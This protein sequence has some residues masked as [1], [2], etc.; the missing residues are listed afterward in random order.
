M[1]KVGKKWISG[2]WRRI[3]ALFIDGLIL[4]AVGFVLGFLLESTFVEIG[5]WGRLIGFSISLVY[6]GVM[7]SVVSNGQTLGKRALNIKVVNS[8]NDTISISKSFARYTVLAI[9]FSLNGIHITNE[10][11]LSYLMYPFSFL[12]FGGFFAIIYLYVCNR[13]TRQSLHDLIFGTYVVNSEV[14]HQKVGIIWK[15]HLLV[16]VILFVVSIIIPIYTSQQAKVESFEDLISTQKTINSFS[17]VT[18]SSVTSG[19]SIFA[20]TSEDSQTK[21]TTYVNVQAFISEDNVADEALARNLGE[22][23]VNTYS[24]SIN[25]DVIKVTLTYG[26]DIGIWSQWFSQTHT[27]APAD[28]LGFE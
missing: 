27:F 13:V 24:E 12:I 4:S 18:Y 11:L 8:S 15:P 16:V 1:G 2:F 7:N 23:V 28:L 5:S 20:S 10:A 9:P 19:S 21:T 3:G 22:V 14:D 26:Y 25:K 17:T 6:F